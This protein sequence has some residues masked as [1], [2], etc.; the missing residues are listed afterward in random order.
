MRTNDM[1]KIRIL[2]QDFT[3]SYRRR[4]VAPREGLGMLEPSKFVYTGA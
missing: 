3:S 1:I 4:N 2:L